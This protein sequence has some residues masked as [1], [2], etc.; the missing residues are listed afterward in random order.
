MLSLCRDI[1]GGAY[2]IGDHRVGAG[3]KAGCVKW[4]GLLIGCDDLCAAPIRWANLQ[5][6]DMERVGCV[7]CLGVAE[8][9]TRLSQIAAHDRVDLH[10]IG[11]HK[12]DY[13]ALY[14]GFADCSR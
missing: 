9:R 7:A 14:L 12:L 5:K 13:D 8:F 3:G 4:D 6:L 11:L 10:R 2:T 1:E